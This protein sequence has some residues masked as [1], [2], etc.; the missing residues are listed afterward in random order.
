V[1]DDFTALCIMKIKATDD[2]TDS[3]IIHVS[4]L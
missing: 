3:R 1:C 4:K 2:S